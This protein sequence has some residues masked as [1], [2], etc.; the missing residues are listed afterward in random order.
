MNEECQH[1]H[2]DDKRRYFDDAYYDIT[3]VVEDQLC[4]NDNTI[5]PEAFAILDKCYQRGKELYQL[6]INKMSFNHGNTIDDLN[7]KGSIFK[8]SAMFT[9]DDTK[10][11]RVSLNKKNIKTSLNSM[12]I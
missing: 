1:H 5:D 10:S 4:K 12:D 11:M 2:G 6:N 8:L 7:E 9:E 3:L